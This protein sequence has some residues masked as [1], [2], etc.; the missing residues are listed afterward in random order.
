MPRKDAPI[1]DDYQTRLFEDPQ[2][3]GGPVH[4]AAIRAVEQARA[5]GM[6]EAIDEAL[7]AAIIA[8]SLAVDRGLAG[9]NPAY[10]LAQL[11]GPYRELLEAGHMT[12]GVRGS[13]IDDDLKRAL[14][15]LANPGTSDLAADSRPSVP[16]G[17]HAGQ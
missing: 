16:D 17:P 5:G 7:G 13:D 9:K 2:P 8:A 6:H 14:D 4:A 1:N 3:A 11:L 10:A 12:P 15:E